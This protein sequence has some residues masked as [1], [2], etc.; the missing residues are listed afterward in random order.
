M[1]IELQIDAE[2]AGELA[3]VCGLYIIMGVC[4]GAG[5][6]W[7]AGDHDGPVL[8]VLGT[9]AVKAD[10]GWLAMQCFDAKGWSLTKVKAVEHWGI[11]NDD[12]LL[13]SDHT[14]WPTCIAL[15]LIAEGK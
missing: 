7:G 12:D 11:T 4:F 9:G 3:Q 15:G 6:D 10:P 2:Q 8:K 14:H 1:L 13:L 5:P